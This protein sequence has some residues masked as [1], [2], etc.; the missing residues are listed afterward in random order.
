MQ[1]QGGV[2]NR[3]PL[4]QVRD[5]VKSYGPTRALAGV[6]L[7]I[8][9]GEVLGVVGHNGAGKSTL[10]RVLS[11]LEELD[12][13]SLEFGNAS[14]VEAA[15]VRMAYQEGSLALELP[16]FEN[17]YLSSRQYFPKRGW[18]DTSCQSVAE[19]LDEIFPG[20]GINPKDYVNDLQLAARQ[21]VEIARATIA[22]DLNVLIL[23]EPTES[24][25][26][27]AVD[28]LYAYVRRVC[29]AGQSVVLVS[30]RLREVLSAC[31]RIAVM[32]DGAAVSVHKASDV[33]ERDL[34]LAMGGD[35]VER[36][37]HTREVA[38][39]DE[40]PDPVLRVPATSVEGKATQ[41]LAHPGEVIG[42][43]GISGQGQE[44]VLDDL[45]RRTTGVHVNASV[46]YV[47][48]DR[49]RAGILPLWTVARNLTIAALPSLSGK[50]IR[51]SAHEDAL[52]DDWVDRLAVR[53]GADAMI[54][55]LSGGNQ[56]KVIVTRAFASEAQIILLDD[57][58]R[59]VD[60]H[61]K[62]ELYELIRSEAKAGRTII[63]YSSENS[64]MHHCDRAYV[65]RAGRVAGELIGDD[66]SDEN[67][68]AL[69]F[70]E[71]EGSAV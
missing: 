20:H 4:V 28:N 34:H 35:I 22:D 69:S 45:W 53:G 50:G 43:A 71:T 46:G 24:L 47:T 49:H 17:V 30:H 66:I 44:D 51:N 42:L 58:F 25:S 16:V 65:L 11:G 12:S 10:M 64:E 62:S 57:P 23:D 2:S 37:V 40:Y 3:V 59:G 26:G 29:E 33:S 52:V 31:D 9:P 41:I 1:M 14:K 36:S 15:G 18:R 6:T 56:Q 38:N 48:G 39:A 32:K 7:D 60:V 63:W 27:A 61:T 21:M 55:S 8:I 67:I 54:T 19:R 5:A 70:A 13:G 68:I